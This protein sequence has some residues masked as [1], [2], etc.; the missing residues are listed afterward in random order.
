M[1]Q[2]QS[3]LAA[4]EA[5][6]QTRLEG[7]VEEWH[8]DETDAQTITFRG[9]AGFTF[10]WEETRSRGDQALSTPPIDEQVRAALDARPLHVALTQ[11]ACSRPNDWL[12]PI[13]RKP[14]PEHEFRHSRVETCDSC[15]GRRTVGCGGC[16][17]SGSVRCGNCS[18]SGTDRVRCRGCG[19]VGYFSRTRM[20]TNNQ[21]EHYR[22][23]CWGCGG[24]GRI[25]ETCGTCRGSGN[26][27]CSRCGG[28]GQ[29]T[30]TDC[31]GRGSRLYLYVRRALVDGRSGLAL[32]KIGFAG[33]ADILRNNWAALVSRGAIAFSGV[34]AKD[35]VAS[36]VL[37]INFD[38][39]ADAARVTAHAGTAS[40]D[41]WSIGSAS[42]V[43]E[44]EPLLT[45]ALDLPD[46]DKDVD[47]VATTEGLAG[48]RLLREAIDV[49]EEKATE[50]KGK[51]RDAYQ[52][53]QAGEIGEEMIRRYGAL[54]GPE[55]AA[56][57]ASMVMKGIEPL[58][59]RVA[60]KSWG[61]S[62]GIAAG[63]GLVAAVAVVVV[64]LQQ[65]ELQETWFKVATQILMGTAVAA[66]IWGI[67]GHWLVRRELKSLS[68]ALDLEHP[69]APP[70]HG[71]PKRGGILAALVTIIVA[72][73][74]PL[75]GW[76]AGIPQTYAFTVDRQ[77]EFAEGSAGEYTLHEASTQYRWPDERS[78]RLA[79]I[80]AGAT[81]RISNRA[82]APWRLVQFDGRHGYIR[83][84][85]I[86]IYAGTAPSGLLTDK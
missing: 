74:L 2:P 59:D 44:G 50:H 78:E 54:V 26:V 11:C 64:I 48:R 42:P 29:V 41:L 32:E 63:I 66:I 55:G 28:S 8:L 77:M 17:A 31:N 30:C 67:V 14:L 23:T 51:S 71:W 25:N 86:D 65:D 24:S 35:E 83:S 58:K 12:R 62:L 13:T 81:I 52:A 34:Q 5:W 16:G 38:A 84:S 46:A 33:W 53:A 15:S 49:T 70:R 10:D 39:A 61:R 6:L 68:H 56:S 7:N 18:G 73:G 9:Q 80:P 4:I 27:T 20:G 22:D 72:V 76:K 57:L 43:V 21:T 37:K 19:G 3:A 40:A 36:E 45:R 60:R 85:A 79:E 1:Q 47:W 82:D 69:L 75:A